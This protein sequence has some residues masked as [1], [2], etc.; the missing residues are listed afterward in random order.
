MSTV[1][2]L[3]SVTAPTLVT[4]DGGAPFWQ[5]PETWTATEIADFNEAMAELTTETDRLAE[6]KHE[7]RVEAESPAV[8]IASARADL[9]SRRQERLDIER[10]RVEDG[11]FD[12]LAKEYGGAHRVGRIRTR[13]GSIMLRPM[14]AQEA[15]VVAIRCANA[16]LSVTDKGKIHNDAQLALVRH[17][18][19]P[20]LDELLGRYITLWGSIYE[21]SDK[22]SNGLAEEASKKG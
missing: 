4:P 14:T 18:A 10:D 17:P 7:V 16:Q 20:K 11:I 1:L 22:L 15:D 12:D 5:F 8:V 6:V 9:A 21:A 2:P 3:Q 13:E 19:R